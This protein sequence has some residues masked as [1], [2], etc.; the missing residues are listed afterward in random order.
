MIYK[1]CS[2]ILPY[3]LLFSGA[4]S[5]APQL[6][7]CPTFKTMGRDP[8]PWLMIGFWFRFSGSVVL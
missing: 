6:K 2:Q 7:L 5:N 1:K 3:A 8:L 4:D